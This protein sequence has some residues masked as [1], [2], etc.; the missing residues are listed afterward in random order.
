MGH[1]DDDH[2]PL[3][4]EMF[5]KAAKQYRVALEVNNSSL[6]KKEKRLNCYENERLTK[7][8]YCRIGNF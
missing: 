7:S 8:L 5:V 4:Y 1:P 6:V 2:N 3:D